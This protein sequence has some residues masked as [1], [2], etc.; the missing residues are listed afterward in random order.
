MV[1]VHVKNVQNNSEAV[2][3]RDAIKNPHMAFSNRTNS[4]CALR[5]YPFF[6][7]LKCE[8]YGSTVLYL[9][10]I[11]VLVRLQNITIHSVIS[12]APPEHYFRDIF[13]IRLYSKEQSICNILL[14]K[15][16]HG[17]S[18]LSFDT[19]AKVLRCPIHTDLYF[20]LYS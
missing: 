8:F 9:F 7:L 14:P 1:C 2:F 11:H 10:E 4:S 20:G 6:T 16:F 13:H 17:L 18:N 19:F 15:S 12:L 3:S 5:N